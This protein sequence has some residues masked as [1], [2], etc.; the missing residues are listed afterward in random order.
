MRQRI[1]STSQPD[2]VKVRVRGR[3]GV[4]WIRGSDQPVV[5]LGRRRRVPVFLTRNQRVP[6]GRH[7]A[8][9]LSIHQSHKKGDGHG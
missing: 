5:E 1:D 8:H 2:K 6:V 3:G 9:R 7:H 4:R